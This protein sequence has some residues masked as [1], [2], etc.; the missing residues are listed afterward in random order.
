MEG[1]LDRGRVVHV[2][3]L[4]LAFVAATSFESPGEADFFAVVLGNG[5][6][7]ALGHGGDLVEARVLEAFDERSV[8]LRINLGSRARF[9]RL[10]GLGRA[11]FWEALEHESSPQ[12]RNLGQGRD[13]H[14]LNCLGYLGKGM[15]IRKA[16]TRGRSSNRGAPEEVILLNLEEDSTAEVLLES[17]ILVLS[18]EATESRGDKASDIS[19][20]NAHGMIVPMEDVDSDGEGHELVCCLVSICRELDIACQEGVSVLQG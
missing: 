11:F 3:V 14:G 18:G 5:G 6:L 7:M 20:S 17:G 10:V 2:R 9:T 19:D 8:C 15:N 13:A 12:R 4:A 16:C 1:L